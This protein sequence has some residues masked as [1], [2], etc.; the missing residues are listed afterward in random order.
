MH[1]EYADRLRLALA[2][3]ASDI[4]TVGSSVAETVTV[5]WPAFYFGSIAP[6]YQAIC[7]VPR[8]LSHFYPLPLPADWSAVNTMLAKNPEL[9]IPEVLSD[10]HAVFIAAYLAHLL[11]DEVWY[12]EVLLPYFVKPE[13][14]GDMGARMLLHNMTLIHLDR[15]A[16]GALPANA[17]EILS[18]A[19]SCHWLPFA[20]DNQL[21]AWQTMITDQLAPGARI[22]TVAIF[23]GRMGMRAEQMEAWLND[24]DW[25]ERELFSKVP[26]AKVEA[27]LSGSL[28]HAAACVTAYLT[29]ER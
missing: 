1:L 19:Q 2:A 4:S 17:G 16:H 13:H 29:G 26:V 11:L 22:Q 14:L 15:K 6:D 8:E 24:A 3:S 12:R 27:A 28:P 5:C 18:E 20:A 10:S 9:A 21:A 25:L 23:A 7:D